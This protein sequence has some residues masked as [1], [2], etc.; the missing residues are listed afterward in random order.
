MDPTRSTYRVWRIR[1]GAFQTLDHVTVDEARSISR[2]TAT[3]ARLLDVTEVEPTGYVPAPRTGLY[4]LLVATSRGFDSYRH[5]ADALGQYQM[6]RAH[7]VPDDRIVLVIADDLADHPANLAPGTVRNR[8]GGPD[9]RAGA[10]IDHRL[11]DV[12]ATIL[13][14]I[15]RGAPSVAGPVIEAGPGDDVY[16]FLVGHAG[17]EGLYVGGDEPSDGV[18]ADSTLLTHEMIGAAVRERFARGG[19][20]RLLI[21]IEACHGEA[22]GDRLDSPG[23]LLL[24]G[25]ARHESS[26]AAG[27]DPALGGVWVTDQ[28]ASVLTAL[29]AEDPSRS[30]AALYREAYLRVPGSHVTVV[31]PRRFGRLGDVPLSD[32]VT[33]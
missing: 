21:A 22:L 5:Q 9:V 11:S 27:R 33:P 10:T 2:S 23:A 16:V 28:F 19:Y 8:V 1:D 29:A 14:D 17:R 3:P 13:A 6:L 32:F 26:L 4:A 18:Q 15:L 20:R 30:L 7:G 25:A 31:N 24:S 12:D